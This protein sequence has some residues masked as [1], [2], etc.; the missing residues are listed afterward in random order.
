MPDDVREEERRKLEHVLSEI[1]LR[2][3]HEDERTRTANAKLTSSL[4]VL[5]I[6]VTLATSGFFVALPI[7]ANLGIAGKALAAFILV[8]IVF[9]C[10]AGVI[11]IRGL[12]PL[13]GRYSVVGMGTIRRFVSSGSYYELLRKMIAERGDAVKADDKINGWKLGVY[14]SAATATVYGLV[15]L[16]LVAVFYLGAFFL[17]PEAFQLRSNGIAASIASAQ[18]AHSYEAKGRHQDTEGMPMIKLSAVR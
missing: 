11:A 17:K 12:D 1:A 6:I 14:R 3:Q 18:S 4:A 7:V 2:E 13:K 10:G 15:S 16:V 8:P 9:F 5:P